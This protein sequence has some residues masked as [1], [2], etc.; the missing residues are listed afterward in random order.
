MTYI[1]FLHGCNV[2]Y[3]FII[4][5]EIAYQYILA[6]V[7]STPTSSPL[8]SSVAVDALAFSIKLP[9][10]LDF[11]NLLKSPLVQQLHPHPLIDL[12]HIFTE[13]GFADLDAWKK[14]NAS[15]IQTYG[16]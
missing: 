8:A 16:T 14:A 10:V 4:I 12:L 5:R 11:T 2:T 13:K 9:T 6:R 1:L 7:S 3:L 15:A